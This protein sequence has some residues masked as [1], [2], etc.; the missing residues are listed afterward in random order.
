MAFCTSPK[1]FAAFAFAFAFLAPGA[2]AAGAVDATALVI[3]NETCAAL[4]TMRSC[5]SGM[6]HVKLLLYRYIPANTCIPGVIL[7]QYLLS[8]IALRLLKIIEP[9]VYY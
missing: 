2:F 9:N 3:V 6:T 1:P 7:K 8:R 5:F 4:P